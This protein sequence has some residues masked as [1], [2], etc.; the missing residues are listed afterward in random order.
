[1]TAA[2]FKLQKSGRGMQQRMARNDA[3]TNSASTDAAGYF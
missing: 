1:M 2:M 3:G